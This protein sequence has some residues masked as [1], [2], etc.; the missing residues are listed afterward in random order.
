[1]SNPVFSYRKLSVLSLTLLILGLFSGPALSAPDGEHQATKPGASS[2]SKSTSVSPSG[3]TW[4]YDLSSGVKEATRRKKWLLVLDG[5]DW[6][7]DCRKLESNVLPD[8]SVQ[9]FLSGYYVCVKLDS[10]HGDGQALITRY[11]VNAIPTV[12]LFTP[13]GQYMS[14]GNAE[15]VDASSFVTMVSNMTSEYVHHR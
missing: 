8:K 1:M 10:D 3:V 7:P 11:H 2:A 14:N 9:A 5:A 15:H 13:N 6:C 12:F 4:L